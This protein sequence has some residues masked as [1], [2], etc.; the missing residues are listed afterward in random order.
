M[1]SWELNDGTERRSG[2]RFSDAKIATLLSAAPFLLY[3]CTLSKSYFGDG[4]QR[5]MLIENGDLESILAPSHMLYPL[6]GLGFYNVAGW[7]GGALVP[8]QVLSALGCSLRRLMYLIS[9]RVTKS[10][11][12]S[13]SVAAM[14]AVSAGFWVY[15]T[16]AESVAP[17]F[18]LYLFLLYAIILHN[19]LCVGRVQDS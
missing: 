16:D 9:A 2:T 7:H 17:P 11:I 8:L 13:L 10:Q 5:S 18:V 14:F 12:R 15:S 19:A 3:L 4:L 6:M 1:E